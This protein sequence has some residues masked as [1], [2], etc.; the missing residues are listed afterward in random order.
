MKKTIL[1]YLSVILILFILELFAVQP[2]YAIDYVNNETKIF[3][4][5][6]MF[7]RDNPYC[8]T[9]RNT[10]T[11]SMIFQPMAVWSSDRTSMELYD[12]YTFFMSGKSFI[13]EGN[14]TKM[15]ESG[16]SARLFDLYRL[17]SNVDIIFENTESGKIE[18]N[19]S[20]M[21]IDAAFHR[22]FNHE[23]TI[24]V[25][26]RGEIIHRSSMRYS[27]YYQTYPQLYYPKRTFGF[28]GSGYNTTALLHNTGYIGINDDNSWK[29]G[30]QLIANS[31]FSLLRKLNILYLSITVSAWFL[32]I[33]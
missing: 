20:A 1:H 12:P 11:G 4:H 9:F 18:S 6:G 17:H 8:H 21:L 24:K 3:D 19:T 28:L 13:N 31:F 27:D 2:L 15:D 23:T 33:I 10:E 7:C 22:A 30:D 14:I 29:T 25:I 16:A 5:P 26:N 32:T